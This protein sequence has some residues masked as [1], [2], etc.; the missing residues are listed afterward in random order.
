[1][2]IKNDKVI[3]MCILYIGAQVLKTSNCQRKNERRAGVKSSFPY[4]LFKKRNCFFPHTKHKKFEESE[5]NDVHNWL[6]I[7]CFKPTYATA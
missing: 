6:I 7:D 5:K 2:F 1:M 4:P 3:Y